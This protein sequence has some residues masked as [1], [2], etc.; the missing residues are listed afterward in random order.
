[1]YFFECSAKNY[2]INEIFQILI[3]NINE[4]YLKILGNEKK[5]RKK[6]KNKQKEKGNIY[7]VEKYKKKRRLWKNDIYEWRNI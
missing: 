1:M 3:D 2:I 7:K 5:E 6:G 4:V